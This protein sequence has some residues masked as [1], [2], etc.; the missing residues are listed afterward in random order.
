M[1]NTSQEELNKIKAKE[2]GWKAKGDAQ[3]K[4]QDDALVNKFKS[5][6]GMDNTQPTPTPST[7]PQTYKSGGT[8]S[9]RADGI[10]IRGKTRA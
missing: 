5:M 6:V 10:A 7:P 9:K 8:A 2:A 1:D 4:A 3:V